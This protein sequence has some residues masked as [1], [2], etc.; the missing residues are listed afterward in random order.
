MGLR[1]DNNIVDGNVDQFDE[2]ADEAHDGKPDGGGHRYLLELFSV[3]FRTPLHQTDRVF[4]ELSSG[5]YE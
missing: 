3:R 5:L 2:E 1:T 4:G